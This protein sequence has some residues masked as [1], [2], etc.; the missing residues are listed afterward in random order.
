[1]GYTVK[2]GKIT[3]RRPLYHF[4]QIRNMHD[5]ER[6]GLLPFGKDINQYMLPGQGAVW[7]TSDPEGNEVTEAHFEY[8]RKHRGE[9]L[10][11]QFENGDRQWFFGADEYGTARITVDA[12]HAVKYL[13]LIRAHYANAPEG[14]AIIE[15]TP[16][17]A[18]WYVSFEP[19]P[20]D[21]IIAVDGFLTD[22]GKEELEAA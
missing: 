17:I 2:G 14:L 22:K 6:D 9:D 7:L 3:K 19:I 13:E 11:K 10:A 8:L 16:G 12:R 21:R 1:M 5:I 18:S 20:G 15:A 4:T